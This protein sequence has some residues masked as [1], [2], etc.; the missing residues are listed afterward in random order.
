MIDDF[1]DQ[2]G[3]THVNILHADIQGSEAGMLETTIRH[4]NNID[5]FFISTHRVDTAHLPCSRFFQAS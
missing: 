4:L 1:L 2:S 3:I 5:Y